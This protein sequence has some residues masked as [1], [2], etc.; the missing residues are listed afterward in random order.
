MR[1][2]ELL[3]G[4]EM[5]RAIAE[6]VYGL[7]RSQARVGLHP[8]GDIEYHWG[9]PVG[10]DLAPRFSTNMIDA[11]EM[12]ARIRERGLAHPY[13]RALSELVRNTGVQYM[14]GLF[15]LIHASPL[16]RCRAA[17]EAIKMAVPSD[18]ERLSE[19]LRLARIEI[20]VLRDALKTKGGE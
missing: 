3:V 10:H 6:Q 7:D 17:I 13:A 9:Y 4:R 14:D 20:G 5:D 11:Y 18:V 15:S 12:E 16:Q 2:D 8:D 1:D 19:E